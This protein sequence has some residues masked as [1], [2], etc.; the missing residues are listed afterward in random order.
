MG[1]IMFYVTFPDRESAAKLSKVLVQE[2]LVACSNI[3]PIES[4][5]HWQGSYTEDDE[6]V[7]MYKT[8]HGNTTKT[9]IRITELHPYEVPC[10]LYWEFSCNL[11]YEK[12][13]RHN[14]TE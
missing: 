14:I 6:Y 8:S 4:T 13:L 2:R 10:I 5:Y 12:W 1:M 3:H 9:E 7:A 11:A